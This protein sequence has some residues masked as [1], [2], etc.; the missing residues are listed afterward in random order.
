MKE[1]F[2]AI[3]RYFDF[4]GRSTRREFWYFALVN[5]IILIGLNA[6]DVI[7]FKG[8]FGSG[9]HLFTALYQCF[10][11]IPSF[12]LA[13]RRFHDTGRSGAWILVSFIPV[14]GVPLLFFFYLLRSEEGENKWGHNP[15]DYIYDYDKEVTEFLV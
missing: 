10:I 11:F 4:K 13:V 1:Y 7:I 9:S 12:A 14:L 5:A 6:L 8:I 15:H 3:D 2:Q